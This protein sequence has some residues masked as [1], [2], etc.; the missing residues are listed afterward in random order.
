M[1]ICTYPDC[2]K[3]KKPYN[4][5]KYCDEHS[6]L[7]RFE[8]HKKAVKK[9]QKAVSEIKSKKERARPAP[10][11]MD[12]AREIHDDCPHFVSR[13]AKTQIERDSYKCDIL[14]RLLCRECEC[15]F[16]PP[17]AEARKRTIRERMGIK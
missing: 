8:S 11:K 4:S 12:T 14:E 3:E 17:V 6:K 2:T 7:I 15:G 5:A 10:R 1:S 16:Y 9:Y 13:K